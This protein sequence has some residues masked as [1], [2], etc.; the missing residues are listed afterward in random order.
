MSTE[1]DILKEKIAQVQTD[2]ERVNSQQGTEKQRMIMQDFLEY[3]KDELRML[4]NNER[5]L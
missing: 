4:E 3:L 5:K 1:S 2:I